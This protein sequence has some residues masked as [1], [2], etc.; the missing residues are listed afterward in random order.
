MAA[1]VLHL[2]YHEQ[3]EHDRPMSR[4]TFA[5]RFPD[6]GACAHHLFEKRWPNG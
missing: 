6:D 2:L 5:E 4:S 3:L 1:N